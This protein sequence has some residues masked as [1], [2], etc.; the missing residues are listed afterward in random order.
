MSNSVPSVTSPPWSAATKRIVAVVALVMV[1]LLLAKIGAEVWTALIITLVLAY[2]LSPLVRTFERWLRPVGN[3]SLRRTLAVILT[4]LLLLAT[5]ALII[6]LIVPATVQQIRSFANQLPDLASSAEQDLKEILQRPI[7]IGG[8]ELVPWNEL[9][10]FIA[11]DNAADQTSLTTTVQDSLLALANPA[12]GVLGGAVTVILTSALSLVMLF[13]LMRDGPT[14]VDYLVQATPESYQGDVRRLLHE[15]G[16]IWNGYLRGQLL[17]GFAIAM[18]TYLS[19]LILGL[20]NPLLLGLLAGLLEFIPNIG[21]TLAAIPAVLF[22]LGTDSSTI[23]SLDGGLLY[24]GVVT[25]NYVLIQQLEAVFLVPRVMGSSLGLHPFVVLLAIFVGSSLFGLLGVVLAA[26]SVATLRLLGRYLR[27]K[28]LDEEAF[29][30]V[31][32]YDA[33]PRGWVYGTIRYLLNAR[34]P[35]AAP[36]AGDGSQTGNEHGAGDAWLR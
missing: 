22:A 3:Y 6:G 19:T 25:L 27:G 10:Q 17:L 12:I 29:P 32:S 24:A 8:Y 2:L 30:S 13:Y 33:A 31:L 35:V 11:G 5:F 9:Q 7:R 18:V 4:W 1:G 16:V 20:P 23:A 36:G 15:L 14:F 26:P 34:F 28:L 21:P